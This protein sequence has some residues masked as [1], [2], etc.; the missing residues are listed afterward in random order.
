MVCGHSHSSRLYG[1]KTTA[2]ECGFHTAHG[3]HV[4]C[5]TITKSLRP[6]L[7]GLTDAILSG[8]K[9]VGHIAQGVTM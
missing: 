4:S 8:P 9:I 5:E 7:Y 1:S 2:V 6:G 3:K